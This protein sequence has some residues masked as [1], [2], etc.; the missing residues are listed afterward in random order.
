MAAV[1]SAGCSSAQRLWEDDGVELA[2]L[3]G[4]EHGFFGSA[5]AGEACRNTRHPDWGIPVFS[6]Y[7]GVRK[8]TAAMLRRVD[9][10]V[11]DL[12]DLGIRCYTYVSTLRGVLEAAAES[13]TDVVVADRPV[14]LPRSVD[15]PVTEPGRTCFL[16]CADL[17][18]SFGMTPGETAR[19]LRSRLQLPVRVRIAKMCGYSRQTR[20]GDNWPPWLPPSPAIHSWDA[21]MCYAATVCFEALPAVDHGR[22]TPLAFQVV[23]GAW[24]SGVE[25]SGFLADLKLPGVRFY[26]HRY[27]AV[28]ARGV[29]RLMDGVRL[30]VTDPIRF[31]PILTAVS[32]VY[33]LQQ[34]YGHSRVWARRGT[35]KTFFDSLFGT[36]QVREALLDGQDPRS[37]A[38]RWRGPCSRFRATR[39]DTLL[40]APDRDRAQASGERS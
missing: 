11:F 22:R 23:G 10:L 32:L 30:S 35:R 21:A 14:P 24:L 28:T 12:Q 26:P 20:R 6:L 33:S 16:A 29:K 8:P 4:P 31:R 39:A 15:G 34:L 1:D 40:Y 27:T 38:A 36:A 37:I 9:T 17:P 5:G 7:G 13:G 18:M 2:C 25:L 3:L 19:W